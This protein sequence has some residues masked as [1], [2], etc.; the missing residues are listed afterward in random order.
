M[1][2]ALSTFAQGNYVLPI[3]TIGNARVLEPKQTELSTTFASKMGITQK[4][5]INSQ[6]ETFPVSPNIAAKINWYNKDKNLGRKRFYSKWRFS[7]TTYH[8]LSYPTP[9]LN[10]S[11]KYPA[12]PVPPQ[13]YPALPTLHNEL[14]I[15]FPMNKSKVCGKTDNYLTLKL[16]IRKTFFADSGLTEPYSTLIYLNSFTFN[17]RSLKFLGLSYDAKLL[18]NL[19]Y[20]ISLKYYALSK[21]DNV[22]ENTGLMY[23]GFGKVKRTRIS[24]GYALDYSLALRRYSVYP[25]FDFTFLF[26]FSKK[27]G[28]M[29]EYLKIY[30]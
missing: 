21:S 28:D 18:N 15:T 11:N 25:F 22:L 1:I 4:V 14:Y 16:G 13:H 17:G 8:N 24:F 6:L 27:S 3:W 23:F 7:I 29:E 19:N 2:I 26:N 12:L 20:Q 10:L 30:N 9:L 5:Q